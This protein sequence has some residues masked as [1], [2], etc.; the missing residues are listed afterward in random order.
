MATGKPS[1]PLPGAARA[2]LFPSGSGRAGE[3]TWGRGRMTVKKEGRSNDKETARKKKP[4]PMKTTGSQTD[5]KIEEGIQCESQAKPKVKEKKRLAKKEDSDWVNSKKKKVGSKSKK[6]ACF[7]NSVNVESHPDS[8][9]L[10]EPEEKTKVLKKKKRKD[11]GLYFLPLEKSQ[12]C[13]PDLKNYTADNQENVFTGKEPRKNI[14]QKSEGDSK[15]TKTKKKK[16]GK[17]IF[18]LTVNCNESSVCHIS[19]KKLQKKHINNS[20][21]KITSKKHRKGIVQNDESGNVIQKKKKKKNKDKHTSLLKLKGNVD[22]NHGTSKH[23]IPV[24]D[25]KNKQG[26]SSHESTPGTERE[27]IVQNSESDRDMTKKSKTISLPAGEANQDHS[28]SIP[29]KY[30]PRHQK[31]KFQDKVL[32][33]KKRKKKF[34]DSAIIKKKKKKLH[35][36]EE[37]VT[38]CVTPSDVEKVASM[39]GKA[40]PVKSNKKKKSKTRAVEGTAMDGIDGG[41]CENNNV[42]YEGKKPKKRKKQRPET[43]AEE[44]SMKKKKKIKMKEEKTD[45]EAAESE[46]DVAVVGERKGNCDEIN[47]DKLRRQALQEEIDRESGKTMGFRSKV[48]S[49]TK[50]GQWSTAAFETSDEKAKFLR[51]MGG[52]KKGSTSVQDPPAITEKPNMALSREGEE[53]LKQA[54][55]VEF[56]RA[57][58]L[59]HHRRVGLGFQPVG[60]KIHIDKCASRSI[61]FED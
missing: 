24:G 18:S 25:L 59:K 29:N 5:I 6:K 13:N 51:L 3:R 16:K 4:K 32:T 2:G 48:K 56:E 52:F 37:E 58:N 49:D 19:S 10:T 53:K 47:I 1:R 11:K 15:V 41:S 23:N 34:G 12:N 36:E 61:K 20:Q 60:K 33:G 30:L 57:V 8:Q 27:N 14:I 50:F 42:P 26:I 28:S 45:S 46:N 35:K 44:P 9:P 55:H 22:N 21:E 38:K 54:L 7:E 43:S 31:D 17:D 40:T 39:G